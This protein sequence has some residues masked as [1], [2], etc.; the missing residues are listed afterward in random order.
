MPTIRLC[1]LLTLTTAA[2]VIAQAEIPPQLPPLPPWGGETRALIAEADDPWVTPAEESGLT[3][4]PT[5]DETV[6]FAHRLAEASPDLGMVSIGA[7]AQGRDIWM[8]IGGGGETDPAT[9]R[10]NGKPTLLIQAGIHAGEIDSKDAGLMLL[11]DLTVGG[12]D[13]GRLLERVNLLFIPILS[14]DGHERSSAHNR[15]NQ[16][17]PREMGWRTNARNLNLNRDY[18]KLDTEEIRA[19]VEVINDYDPDLYVDVHVTNGE[20]YQYDITYGWSFAGWSPSIRA[21]LDAKLRPHADAALA[22]A[23]HVPGPLVL[24]VNGR[25][26]DDGFIG[27]TAPPRFSNGYGDARHLPTVLV[28]NHSLKPY[29]QRV[30]GT[31]VFLESVLE[32]LADEGESLTEASAADRTLRRETVPLAFVPGPDSTV[33]VDFAG[34]AAVERDSE[35]SGGKILDWTGEPVDL[36]VKRVLFDQPAL[37][38][39]RPACYYIPAARADI[40]ERLALHGIDVERIEEPLTVEVEMLRLPEARLADENSS[41]L[42]GTTNPF[43]GHARVDPG[44]PVAESHTRTFAPGSF[45]VDTD[46]ALGTLAMLLLEPQSPDSFFQWGFFLE[47]LSRTE[48]ADDDVMERTAQKMLAADPELAAEFERALTE[49]PEFATDPQAR[50]DWFYR[51]TPWYDAGYL[52]YPVARSLPDSGS[53]VAP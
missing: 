33:E 11:R 13:E 25:D 4:T 26:L 34:I 40:A 8:L 53:T 49:D 9:I 29:D 16:R 31:Y 46:Q 35:I 44:T 51:R 28:E 36:K 20:D 2:A 27:W 37:P 38:V 39:R 7:S 21:W 5:Y 41:Q 14:V 24:S 47:I 15:V 45:I 6:A 32:L 48:Y 18:A 3:E 12:K 43:E 52:L 50:L 22:A 1:T 23:G 30:L 10:D 19:V 17:G 42:V